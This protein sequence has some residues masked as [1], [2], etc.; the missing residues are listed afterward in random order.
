[1]IK[2]S[3]HI[4]KKNWEMVLAVN[5]SIRNT[6]V[7]FNCIAIGSDEGDILCFLIPCILLPRDNKKEGHIMHILVILY[8]VLQCG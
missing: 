2:I 4:V 6:K 7:T 5:I 3:P 1:M 8:H